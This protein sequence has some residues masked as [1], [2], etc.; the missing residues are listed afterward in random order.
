MPS[1]VQIES[2]PSQVA[3]SEA[4]SGARPQVRGKFFFA[5]DEK[6]FIRG[7]TYGPFHPDTQGCLYRNV[8]TVE[9][10]FARMAANGINAVRTYTVPP[11]WLLDAAHRHGL[12]VMVGIPWEQHIAFL[13]DSRT[14]HGIVAKVSEAVRSCGGHPAVLCFAIGNE[15]AASIVRW[16]GRKR[17]EAFL[18]KLYKAAKRED[19]DALITYVNFPPTEYLQLDFL[20]FVSFNVYLERQD[21]LEAYLARLQNIAGNRP[22]LMAEVGLDSRR[23]GLDRQ[24]SVLK[25]QLRS[26]FDLGCSG[27]F[28]FAWTDEW[29]RGGFEI[30][31][32]DFGLTTRNGMSKPALDNVGRAFANAPFPPDLDWPSISVVVCSY[33]GSVTI[34]QTLDEVTKLDYPN[35]EVIVVDDGSTDRTPE[36]AREYPGVRLISVENGGLSAARNIGMRAATGKIIAYIDDD[37]YPDRHWLRYIAAGFRRSSHVA[38]GGPNIPPP[39]DGPIAECVANAPG[40]PIHVLLTDDLAE[41][42]PG[43][44]FAVLRSALEQI[45]GFDPLYRVAGDDVDACW[46]LQERGGTLGFAPAAVVWHHR[47]N[48]IRTYWR[49]Q[50]GYG[51]AEALLERKWPLKYNAAGHL[52][53]QGR[54]YGPG[55]LRWFG[56][57]SR[58]YQ[59]TWG[60][61]LFQHLYE[62][63]PGLIQNLMQMPEW[64]LVAGSMLVLS[65]LG[66]FWTPLLAFVPC[67]A[68]AIGL[69]LAQAGLSASRARFSSHRSSGTRLRLGALTAALFAAQ[70]IARLWGRLRY[71]LTPWRSARN[72]ESSG[73]RPRTETLWTRNWRSPEEWLE[74]V[75][76]FSRTS[77]F[78]SRG[79]DFDSWDLQLRG[80]LTGAARLRFAI[81]EHG[82]GQ[83][84]LRCRVVP[85]GNRFAISTVFVMLVLALCAAVGGAF[86]PALVI[87]LVACFLASWMIRDCV[88][89]VGAGVSAFRRLRELQ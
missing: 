4:R 31:D 18:L 54:L 47:R 75:E 5:G 64:Y 53:W 27:V 68:L 48:S 23:N 10:D 46:R 21:R 33:N 86:G 52:T 84:F 58:I 72:I 66:L 49:Q 45:G 11:V 2:I 44:N 24:A 38:I 51:K 70:P 20:D 65:A 1:P 22:L 37:A 8:A 55:V 56:G 26:V 67:T 73:I 87:G 13:D 89:A 30:T 29:S 34:R 77:A 78:V 36:I 28:V 59:G 61:A 16:H 80:G 88:R 82:S 60:T 50:K 3:L 25:W 71:G 39:G 14:A 81:E 83:Q 41:H 79:G 35:F 32:W 74:H 69:P 42:I 40:G 7:V 12:W 6:L 85:H 43:C 19:P 9:A 17:I 15:I 76:N 62:P 57:R 63:T